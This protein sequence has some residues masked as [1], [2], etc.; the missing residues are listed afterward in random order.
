MIQF[1]DLQ[2]LNNIV[3]A[4]HQ[5]EKLIGLSNVVLYKGRASEFVCDNLKRLNVLSGMI[6]QENQN[7][8]HIDL[9]VFDREE[10]YASLML[11]QLNYSGILDETFTIKC[12][13]VKLVP[14]AMKDVQPNNS[15]HNLLNGDTIFE[16][17]QDMSFS[18]VCM[19]LKDKGQQLRHKSQQRQSM[20]IN[21]MKTFLAQELRS[22]HSEHKALYLRELCTFVEF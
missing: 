16:H 22:L 13:K 21:D 5:I 17:V 6:D 15:K 4:V 7:D 19:S 2:H 11:S 12:G 9:F 8:M 1:G 20:N 3:Q 10:D 18:A 14:E